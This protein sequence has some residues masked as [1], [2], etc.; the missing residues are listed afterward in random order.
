M[1]IYLKP[2][3]TFEYVAKRSTHSD[4]LTRRV[5]MM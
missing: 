2:A 5:V 3:V 1:E 4:V